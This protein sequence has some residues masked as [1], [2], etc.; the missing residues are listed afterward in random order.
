MPKCPKCDKDIASISGL[1]KHLTGT[2]NYGGH[3]LERNVARRLAEAAAL[4]VSDVPWPTAPRAQQQPSFAHAVLDALAPV[5]SQVT[6]NALTP[7]MERS[8]L[9][10]VFRSMA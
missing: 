6:P 3:E 1:T 4:D 10:S 2:Y 5:A 7:D 9:V 8:F